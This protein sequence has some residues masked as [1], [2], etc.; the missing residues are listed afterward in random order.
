MCSE[1]YMNTKAEFCVK[2]TN[3][4]LIRVQLCENTIC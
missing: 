2:Y 3:D 4:N 1:G